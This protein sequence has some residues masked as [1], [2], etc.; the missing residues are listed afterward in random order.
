M[1]PGACTVPGGAVCCA[2]GGA[3]GCAVGGASG[4][5]S[6]GSGGCALL[7]FT[8]LFLPVLYFKDLPY[9]TNLLDSSDPSIMPYSL[10]SDAII[11]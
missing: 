8:I 11:Q 9:P 4:C 2:V 5:A 10:A 1:V 7:P 6:C 3:V